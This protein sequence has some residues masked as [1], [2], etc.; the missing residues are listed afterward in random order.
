V[1]ASDWSTDSGLLETVNL[2][3]ISSM[4]CKTKGRWGF[5]ATPSS[6]IK[7]EG[8]QREGID[9]FRRREFACVFLFSFGPPFIWLFFSFSYSYNHLLLWDAYLFLI[10]PLPRTQMV[11]SCYSSCF[12]KWRRLTSSSKTRALNEM[13]PSFKAPI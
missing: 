11:I 2:E 4:P 7:L 3:G 8:I 13:I 1:S 5:P 9:S 12:P 6:T 10:N